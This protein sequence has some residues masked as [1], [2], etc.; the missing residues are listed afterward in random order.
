MRFAAVA[1]L[2]ACLT[3]AACGDDRRRPSGRTQLG[4]SDGATSQGRE[5]AAEGGEDS[6]DDPRFDAGFDPRLDAGFFD[7]DTPW[8]GGFEHPDAAPP[9]DS[10][11]SDA[12][13]FDAAPPP[14]P[15][16]GFAPDAAPPRDAGFPDSGF[17]DAAGPD[18]G[19]PAQTVVSFVPGTARI[20]LTGS[21]LEFDATLRY[22]NSGPGSE[23]IRVTYA[24]ATGL[25]APLQIFAVAPDH[26][27]PVGS[28]TRFVAKV[29]GSG[30]RALDPFIVSLICTFGLSSV[31]IELSNGTSV[32]EPVTLECP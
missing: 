16:A 24:E 20:V 29:P 12:G 14:P 8:D 1:A 32:L 28:T 15:D 23:L 17:P 10:G 3:L 9:F 13:F 2:A 6:G 7:A 19:V 25:S 22:E 4:T 21:D 30:D 18:G 11:S 26:L 5:D 31:Y 27:A